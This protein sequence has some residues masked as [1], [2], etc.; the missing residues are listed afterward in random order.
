MD[1]KTRVIWEGGP[2]F[3]RAFSQRDIFAIKVLIALFFLG[4]L[5]S[6][7]EAGSGIDPLSRFLPGLLSFGSL[8]WVGAILYAVIA[9]KTSGYKRVRYL[10]TKDCAFVL[11]IGK[12]ISDRAPGTPAAIVGKWPLDGTS[13]PSIIG[14]HIFFKA[15]PN[16]QKPIAEN[17][18]VFLG[19]V[20]EVYETLIAQ[21]EANKH[22]SL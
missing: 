4:W 12:R 16:R 22:P 11:G 13:N 1:E 19:N 9:R 14:P 3:L 2:K 6:N 5:L 20:T 21:I 17:G 8:L 15:E 7:I 18:F 10:V